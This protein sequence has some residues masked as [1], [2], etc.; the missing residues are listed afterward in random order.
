MIICDDFF[1]LIWQIKWMIWNE[2][3]SEINAYEIRAMQ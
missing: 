1:S 2:N 3:E